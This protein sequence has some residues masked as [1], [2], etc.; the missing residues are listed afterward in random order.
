VKNIPSTLKTWLKPAWKE[1]GDL[2]QDS[3]SPYSEMPGGL[4][5]NEQLRRAMEAPIDYEKLRKQL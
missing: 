2:L 4:E 3:T 5:Q 1:D